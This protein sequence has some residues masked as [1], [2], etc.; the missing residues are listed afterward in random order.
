MSKPNPQQARN[1]DTSQQIDN[2]SY[3]PTYKVKVVELLTENEAENAVVRQ[4]PIATEAK[5][6]EMIG[7]YALQYAEDSGDNNILYVG[8]APIGSATSSAVWRIQRWD[9]TTGAIKKWADGNSNFDNI[10]DNRETLTY[11]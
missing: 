8:E 5:Q 6:D 3:D 2:D 4:K 11:N 9:I 7:N 10:W 1:K